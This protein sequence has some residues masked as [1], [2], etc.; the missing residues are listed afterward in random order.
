MAKKPPPKSEEPKED[1]FEW[2]R[3]YPLLWEKHVN[4]KKRLFLTLFR[5]CGVI[6]HALKDAGVGHTAHYKWMNDDVYP[7]EADQYCEAF[8]EAHNHSIGLL[9]QE[10]RRRA[11]Q[12]TL[13]DVYFQGR[14]VGRKRTYSDVLLIF[15]LKGASPEKY[16]D[17]TE[18]YD[19][20][21]KETLS[22]EQI[23]VR[24]AQLTRKARAG[25]P[26][27]GKAETA[28]PDQRVDSG[29]DGA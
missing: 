25:S 23:E 9:E 20:K 24:I 28:S 11:T 17:R 10:A 15:L 29:A 7:E 21:D 8:K 3:D 2:L 6:S 19:G 22:H 18:I 1:P 26:A 14:V 27:G 13:E 16:R 12:G 5:S 4:P